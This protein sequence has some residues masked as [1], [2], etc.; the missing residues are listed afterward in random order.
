MGKFGNG[1]KGGSD[2]YQNHKCNAYFEEDAKLKLDKEDWERF[3]WYAERFNNHLRSRKFEQELLS[4]SD[5]ARRHMQEQTPITWQASSFYVDALEQLVAN[6][7][8]LMWSYVFGFF[9]PI[10]RPE[11]NKQLFEHRQNEFERHTEILSQWIDNGKEEEEDKARHIS[12]NRLQVIND[13]K[14]CQ[15]S[16]SSLLDVA[17]N[18]FEPDKPSGGLRS[19]GSFATGRPLKKSGGARTKPARG[20]PALPAISDDEIRRR[21]EEERRNRHEAQLERQAR[22]QRDRD[23]QAERD[24]ARREEEEQLQKVMKESMKQVEPDED[25]LLRRAI[26]ESMH[27]S[28]PMTDEE[29]EFQ[30]ALRLSLLE[31]QK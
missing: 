21:D 19:S 15:N 20:T 11:I 8:V 28:V 13:T 3:R 5:D 9:R 24:R 29:R 27:E 25:E 4:K 22:E 26:A 16:L 10:K 12:E 7:H 1:P 14:L 2:G 18:A 31:G 6:R 23:R 30:E 17:A